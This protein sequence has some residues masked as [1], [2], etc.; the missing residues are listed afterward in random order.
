M[1]KTGNS[2]KQNLEGKNGGK[3]RFLQASLGI[4][5]VFGLHASTQTILKVDETGADTAMGSL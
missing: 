3:E 5:Q 1:T 4:L 2:E